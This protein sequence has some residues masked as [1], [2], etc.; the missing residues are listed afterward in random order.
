M[1]IIIATNIILVSANIHFEHF[2]IQIDSNLCQIKL[3]TKNLCFNPKNFVKIL[4]CY[5]SSFI[6]NHSKNIPL[7]FQKT[8]KKYVK[9]SVFS[10]FGHFCIENR[11]KCHFGM[12]PEWT[13]NGP[14]MVDFQE[15]IPLEFLLSKFHLFQNGRVIIYSK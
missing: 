2:Q 1:T 5:H 7:S 12:V 4:V 11:Q 3:K 8:P 9:N 6:P 10:D 13:L 14:G 15:H